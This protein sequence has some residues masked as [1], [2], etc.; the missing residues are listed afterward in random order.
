MKLTDAMKKLV[1]EQR[2]GFVASVNPD[3][4]PN[5][6]PKGTF[7]ILDDEHLIY[8]DIRSPNTARNIENGSRVEVNFVDPFLR[9]GFRFRGRAAVLA[10]SS[11][12]G[13]AL[14]A[15]VPGWQRR[16]ETYRAVV[17]IRVEHAAPLISPGY[18]FG[19]TE[20]ETRANWTKNFRLL[21]PGER[22]AE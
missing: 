4:T 22:F 2:L 19:A 20:E 11:E 13:R 21:Q 16:A 1:R 7:E 9:K 17:K 14:F 6:S 5:L 18:D 12:E 8:L 3:G 15:R 10:P